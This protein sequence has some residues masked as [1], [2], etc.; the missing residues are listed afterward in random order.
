MPYALP[1]F[2]T[3]D[4]RKTGGIGLNLRAAPSATG[5]RLGTMRDNTRVPVVGVARQNFDSTSGTLWYQVRWGDRIGY[6]AA[7]YLTTD[8]VFTLR[9][10]MIGTVDPQQT[11]G[12]GLNLRASP[13]RTSQR[14]VTMRDNSPVQIIG[15]ALE[16]FTPGAALWFLAQFGAQR[17]YCA[18][19]YLSTTTSPGPL[20]T[21]GPFVGVWPVIYPEHVVTAPFN[22]PRPEFRAPIKAHEGIDL[23]APNGTP[24]LAWADGKVVMTWV[25]D[26][27]SKSGNHAYGHHVK[28]FHSALGLFSMYC[29]LQQFNV[30]KDQIV[31]AGQPIGL[32]DNTGN[33]RGAHLHF[34]LVDPANGLDGYVYPKVIDPTPYLPKPYSVIGG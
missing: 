11:G 3:V 19:S 18:A 21:T 13:D 7:D 31:Q 5:A 23:R 8:P 22:Q 24:I 34:M 14:L 17:G 27:V 6:C 4:P 33:S 28:L 15:A 10:P 32:A 26:G 2:A 29:H 12:M 9:L 20:L 1:S 16:R 25:W 30:A